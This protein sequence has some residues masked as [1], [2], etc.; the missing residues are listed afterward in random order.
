MGGEE[1]LNIESRTANSAKKIRYSKTLREAD[2]YYYIAL[3]LLE[4]KYEDGVISATQRDD[5]MEILGRE[6]RAVEKK[7]AVEKRFETLELLRS[8]G[9]GKHERRNPNTKGYK[10]KIVS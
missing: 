2:R 10:K 9:D 3:G 5:L 8:K 4:A 1:L 7:L 6:H